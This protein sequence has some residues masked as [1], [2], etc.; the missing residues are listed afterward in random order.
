MAYYRSHLTVKVQIAFLPNKE[1]EY[2]STEKYSVLRT[3][4]SCVF[5]L[6]VAD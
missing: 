3:L 2:I 4:E 5:V 6:Q 1:C